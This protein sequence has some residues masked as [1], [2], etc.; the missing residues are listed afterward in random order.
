MAQKATHA[1]VGLLTPVNFD[2]D[3]FDA[4]R[5]LISTPVPSKRKI[6]FA[7]GAN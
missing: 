1:V 3:V 7:C 6:G 5:K 4:I 2:A